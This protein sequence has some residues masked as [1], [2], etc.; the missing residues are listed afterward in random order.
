M[1][2]DQGSLGSE[3]WERSVE[4]QVQEL[5]QMGVNAIRVTHN[6]ASQVLIDVCNREGI[7]LVEEAFDCWL[8]GKAGNTEDYG[9]WFYQTIENG[10]QIVN[11]REGEKWAEVDLKAMVRRGRNNPSIIMWSLGNEI[12]Q[13][14]IDGNVTGQY[15]EVAKN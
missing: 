3:A 7:M 13:R 12:F 5:K 9:K 1:H 2:H 6:P 14:L 11:G 4:R 8:S 15:P 10:N